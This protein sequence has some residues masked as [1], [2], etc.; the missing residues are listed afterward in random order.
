MK[1]VVWLAL[2]LV[3]LL[4]V[5]A[6]YVGWWYLGQVRPD[7][8]RAA[9]SPS[10]CSRPTP[11]TRSRRGC[12]DEGLIVDE[13]VFTW[14]VERKGGLEITPGFYQLPTDDHMGNVLSRLRTPPEQT[15]R[16]VTFPE[17][18]THR[19]DGA[20]GWTRPTHG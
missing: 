20:S 19:A 15:Y 5:V 2:A 6:G 17:G 10:R 16:R 9:R 3:V 13:S 11:S 7:G 12:E 14:Y 18:F 4:I 1:W 8:E